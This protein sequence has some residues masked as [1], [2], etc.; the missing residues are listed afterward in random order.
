M[1]R[2]NPL[3]LDGSQVK[4]RLMAERTAH[5]TSVHIDWLRF[6]CLLRN[7]PFPA[8]DILFHQYKDDHGLPYADQM[9]LRD[10][11]M[12][13]EYRQRQHRNILA[14]C[15]DYDFI[16][17][18]QAF[19]LASDI[20]E[21]LG[22]DFAIAPEIRKGHDFYKFRWS[23]E[24]NGSECGWVG[25]L[26]SG[27]SPRQKSQAA[28]IHA[29]LYGHACTFAQHGWN[30][31]L[32]NIVDSHDA[33]ITRA[34]LALDYFDGLPGGMESLESD[35]KTGA[36]D[37]NGKRPKASQAGDWFN[38]AERSLYIG[39]REAGKQ[40]NIY[41]KGDQLFGRD[42]QSEWVRIELRYGNKLRVLPSD[43]L[44]RPADFFAGAS[45]WH[46]LQI[47]KFG[48][49]EKQ[50]CPQEK[51]L[52]QQTVIA[53]VTRNVRWAFNTAA[54]TIAAA[55]HFLGDEF[56][57]LVT[58]QKLP[59]RLQKFSANELRTAFVNVMGS[60]STGGNSSPIAM[61]C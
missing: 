50:S 57:E 4:L 8:V 31:R 45:D 41:E 43:I 5:K 21:A 12:P 51:T 60:F 9:S 32:A 18:A 44:R 16:P 38:G 6:T 20:C 11:D 40:T 46:A 2:P 56:L 28:T 29:N 58:N 39:S 55:F 42:T 37:V 22:P 19:Q 52:S 14:N 49:L 54:P 10:K 25:F 59:G 35:Y 53:E 17:S 13:L 26:A 7:T 23:I 15:V 24:R 61:A 1:T 36:F 30:D 48:H 47:A 27:D 3:V 34:D 33:K